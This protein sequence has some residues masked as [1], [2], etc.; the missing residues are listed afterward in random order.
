VQFA[1]EGY[2]FRIRPDEKHGGTLKFHG[3]ALKFAPSY[4][5]FNRPGEKSV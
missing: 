3:I 1:V 5:R 4:M 2:A